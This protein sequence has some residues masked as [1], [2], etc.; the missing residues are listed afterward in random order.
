[1]IWDSVAGVYDIYVNII[2]RKTHQELIPKCPDDGSD[3]AMNLRADDSFAED[4]GLA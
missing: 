1:M 2:N 3:V 4:E